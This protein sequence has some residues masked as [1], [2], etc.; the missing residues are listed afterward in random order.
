M[1]IELT[2]DI[3]ERL[4]GSKI[5]DELWLVDRVKCA[6]HMEPHVAIVYGWGTL[7]SSDKQYSLPCGS[8]R[9]VGE[10][11]PPMLEPSPSGPSDEE[12]ADQAEVDADLAAEPGMN[13]DLDR[14]SEEVPGRRWSAG[15]IQRGR[16]ALPPDGS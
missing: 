9:F 5:G 15:E 2:V 16:K 14:K 10:S 7:G 12:L 13:Q 3:G 4:P 8:W 11:D 6:I 1:R